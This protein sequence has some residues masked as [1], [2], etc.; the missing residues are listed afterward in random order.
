[1]PVHQKELFKIKSGQV[2]VRYPEHKAEA[3]NRVYG[4]TLPRLIRGLLDELLSDG[5]LNAERDLGHTVIR[6][7]NL[8]M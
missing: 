2:N 1:M 4:R 8:I 3:L 7:E 6:R 5:L